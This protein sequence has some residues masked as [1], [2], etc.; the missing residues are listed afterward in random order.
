M[1]GVGKLKKTAQRLSDEFKSSVSELELQILWGDLP[2]EKREQGKR[3][4][5]TLKRNLEQK[6]DDTQT[7]TL[8]GGPAVV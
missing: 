1:F 4:L 7:R 6:K 3:I 2:P 8:G 5:E